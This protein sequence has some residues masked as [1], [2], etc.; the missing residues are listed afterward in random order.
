VAGKPYSTRFLLGVATAALTYKVPP[1]LTAVVKCMTAINNTTATQAWSVQI[2]GAYLWYES[3]PGS[4]TRVL[5][6]L[7]IVVRAGETMAIGGGV[8]ITG[9]ASGYLLSG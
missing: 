5:N 9:H 4:A 6:S 1:G 8:N 7:H 3:I 2:D